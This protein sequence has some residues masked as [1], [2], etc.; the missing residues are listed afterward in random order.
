MTIVAMIRVQ[1][2]RVDRIEAANHLVLLLCLGSSLCLFPQ[3]HVV[4]TLQNRQVRRT[5]VAVTKVKKKREEGKIFVRLGQAGQ[6]KPGCAAGVGQV[7][8]YDREKCIS[9][10]QT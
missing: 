5:N 8:F 10:A 6:G 7:F 3:G 9:Y 2:I 4:K 1:A